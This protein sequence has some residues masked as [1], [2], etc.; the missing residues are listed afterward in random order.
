M[1]MYFDALDLIVSYS[2]TDLIFGK[3]PSRVCPLSAQFDSA[4][5][6]IG[7]N[8][9]YP[10]LEAGTKSI[11]EVASITLDEF[12]ELMTGDPDQACFI[13]DGGVFP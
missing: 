13:F 12:V 9:L 11:E 5:L 1:N 8:P 7:K 2:G 4:W 3:V 6:W 10:P